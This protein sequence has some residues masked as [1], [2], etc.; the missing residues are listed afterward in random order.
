MALALALAVALL[1][2]TM[3]TV[4]ELWIFS[5]LNCLAV[6][7]SARITEPSGAKSRPTNGPSWRP[8]APAVL[9][10]PQRRLLPATTSNLRSGVRRKTYVKCRR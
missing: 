10:G 7:L 8:R 9:L 5:S 1:E 2:W 6:S 4:P 3:S